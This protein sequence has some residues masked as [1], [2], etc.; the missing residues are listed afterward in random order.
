MPKWA[1]MRQQNKIS[2]VNS[3]GLTLRVAEVMTWQ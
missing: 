1:E 2:V 3:H